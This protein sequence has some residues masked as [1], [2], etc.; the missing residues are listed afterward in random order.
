MREDQG[1]PYLNTGLRNGRD[2]HRWNRVAGPAQG[3]P[4]DHG[5]GEKEEKGRCDSQEPRTLADHLWI[6]IKKTNDSIPKGQKH[7]SE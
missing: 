5:Q 4:H 2:Q 7:G 6:T 3:R 1:H